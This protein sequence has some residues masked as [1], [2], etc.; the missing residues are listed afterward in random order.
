[1]EI[2]TAILDWTA[3]VAW[4]ATV[5]TIILLFR[6]QIRDILLRLE[7]VASRA[8]SQAFDLQLGERLKLS[9]RDAMES[10]KP[11]TV[12]EAK[13][14]AVKE[15][16]KAL[17]IFDSLSRLP[18]HQQHKDLLLKIAKG[19]EAGIEWTYGGDPADSP[20]RTMG[21]LIDHGLVQFING[22]YVAHSLARDYIFQVHPLPSAQQ[23]RQTKQP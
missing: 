15:A 17:S 23:L 2:I 9:F 18:L 14:V 4:P 8:G 12:E 16:D 10:S 6:Q 22:R 21:L 7:A 11:A 5:L 3:K 1:M 20:G 13:A 19:G